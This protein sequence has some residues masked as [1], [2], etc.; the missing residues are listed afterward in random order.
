MEPSNKLKANGCHRIKVTD[1]GGSWAIGYLIKIPSFEKMCEARI[2]GD[3]SKE[4][5]AQLPRYGKVKQVA[6]I[7]VR[8]ARGILKSTSREWAA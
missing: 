4:R 5:E 1:V 2:K 7:P 3:V 6:K 8:P